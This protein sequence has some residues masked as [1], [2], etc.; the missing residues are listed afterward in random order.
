MNVEVLSW[1][2]TESLIRQ[3]FEVGMRAA[4]IRE[5]QIACAL[6]NQIYG[7]DVG[8]LSHAED[9]SECLIGAVA[10]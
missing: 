1:I 6:I 10:V 8:S 7:V 3:C 4:D 9:Q 5:K 2:F